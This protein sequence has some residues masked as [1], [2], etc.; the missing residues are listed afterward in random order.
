MNWRR[1]LFRA[2][3]VSSICWVGAIGGNGVYEWYQ[4]HRDI[5]LANRNDPRCHSTSR[6]S[7]CTFDPDA[8]LAN[9]P[10]PNAAPNPFDKFDPPIVDLFSPKPPSL[11]M[12]ILLAVIP[13]ASLLLFGSALLWIGRGF[14]ESTPKP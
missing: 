11:W 1:G 4:W 8:Y 6:P 2:W 5:P 10:Q 12:T 9:K 13:P 7:W 14:R 3:L